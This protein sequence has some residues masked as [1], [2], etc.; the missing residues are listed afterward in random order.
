MNQE[1]KFAIIMTLLSFPL[2]GLIGHY[3]TKIIKSKNGGGKKVSDLEKQVIEL[4][5]Q[6]E[7]LQKRLN[8]VETIVVDDKEFYRALPPKNEANSL[9][10]ELEK[11]AKEKLNGSN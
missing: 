3:V 4:A 1:L 9:E 2:F 8:N 10:R 11:I 6:N 5:Q 7:Q